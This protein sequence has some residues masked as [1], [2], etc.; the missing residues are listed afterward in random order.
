MLRDTWQTIV[1]H[2]VQFFVKRWLCKYIRLW[3]MSTFNM[4]TLHYPALPILRIW[5][6]KT[7]SMV[8]VAFAHFV[9]LSRLSIFLSIQCHRRLPNRG[10]SLEMP[11]INDEETT[12]L[13]SSSNL[14]RNR[15]IDNQSSG[16]EWGNYRTFQSSKA[17]SLLSTVLCK[18]TTADRSISSE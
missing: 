15:R 10:R 12:V 11:A 17:S 5:A 18:I 3:W 13:A 14:H 8:L 2:V 1:F 6:P 7:S 16:H 9:S 4:E